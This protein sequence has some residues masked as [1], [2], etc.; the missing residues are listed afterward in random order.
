MSL[1]DTNQVINL[2]CKKNPDSTT[3]AAA[4]LVQTLVAATTLVKFTSHEGGR[5]KMSSSEAMRH[6][7]CWVICSRDRDTK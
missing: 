2:H 6:W 7:D 4:P 5:E 3:A 1:C